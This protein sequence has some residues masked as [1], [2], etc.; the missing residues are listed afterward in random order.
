[1]QNELKPCPFCGGKAEIVETYDEVYPYQACCIDCFCQT[2]MIK[3]LDE[4]KRIWNR[5]AD[6]V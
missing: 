4:A 2:I 3:S 5:R 1:M 6:N